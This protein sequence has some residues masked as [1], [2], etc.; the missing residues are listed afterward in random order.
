MN[1]YF[2]VKYSWKHYKLLKPWKLQDKSSGHRVAC[3]WAWCQLRLLRRKAPQIAQLMS[4]RNAFLTV[5]GAG[6]LVK[7]TGP[8]WTGSGQGLFRMS[9]GPYPV[10][11]HAEKGQGARWCLSCKHTHL[12]KLPNPQDTQLLGWGVTQRKS[13]LCPHFHS[14][15]L[16]QRFYLDKKDSF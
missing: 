14:R 1:I 2:F 7:I 11:S 13:C 6:S 16:A 15:V 4:N 8:A 3:V 12:P 5:L 10:S 9:G